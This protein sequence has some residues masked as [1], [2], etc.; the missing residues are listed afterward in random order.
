[1]VVRPL[2]LREKVGIVGLEHPIGKVA[3]GNG[4]QVKHYRVQQK[5]G[6]HDVLLLLQIVVLDAGYRQEY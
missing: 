3:Q 1:M 4:H 2:R 5:D 6:S